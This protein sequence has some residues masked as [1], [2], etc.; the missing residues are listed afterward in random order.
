MPGCRTRLRN[1]PLI[2]RK[3]AQVDR[4]GKGGEIRSLQEG[5][6]GSEVP[7]VR[8]SPA[9]RGAGQRED[10]PPIT[11]D[12]GEPPFPRPGLVRQL[13][14]ELRVQLLQF[15]RRRVR[16]FAQNGAHQYIHPVGGLR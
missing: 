3:E 6:E 9:G 2:A 10:R 12:R 15:P 4:K 8:R 11:S 14:E 1:R 5:Q 7:Q 13:A 16:A